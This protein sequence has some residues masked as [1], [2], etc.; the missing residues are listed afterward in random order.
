VLLATRFAVLPAF[1]AQADKS[2]THPRGFR[3]AGVAAGIKRSNRLDVGLLVSDEPC[4]SAA[5]FT[6]SAAAAAPVLLT[7]EQGVCEGLRAA[8][9]NSGNANAARGGMRD[10]LVTWS[11]RPCP[12]DGAEEVAVCRPA[13]WPCS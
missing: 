12:G 13:S 2:V 3:A 7:R 9:V 11:R 8:V 10:A 6:R 5:F 1:A 4:V